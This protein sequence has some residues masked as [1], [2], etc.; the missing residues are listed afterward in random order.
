MNRERGSLRHHEPQEGTDPGTERTIVLLHYQ[1][2]QVQ[3]SLTQKAEIV[4]NAQRYIL[5]LSIN[6][7]NAAG[8]AKPRSTAG[9]SETRWHPRENI[10]VYNP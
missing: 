10:R 4:L 7:L 6:Y 9:G 3:R 5:R 1:V 2:Q 8:W